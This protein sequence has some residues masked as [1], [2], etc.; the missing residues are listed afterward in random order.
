[1]N[2]TA[3]FPLPLYLTMAEDSPSLPVGQPRLGIPE[4]REI[5]D[6]HSGICRPY[7]DFERAYGI[8]RHHENMISRQ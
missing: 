2:F 5:S 1:M 8:E 7:Y 3:R 4:V 6:E